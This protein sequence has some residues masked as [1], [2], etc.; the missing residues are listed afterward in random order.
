VT[1]DRPEVSFLVSTLGPA[2]H[3]Q[4]LLDSLA[5]A[6]ENVALELI[7]CDQSA[8]QQVE[9]L[10]AKEERPFAWRVTRSGRGLSRG[11]NAALSLARGQIVAFPDD[12]L[13][14]PPG[15]VE[16]VVGR[17]QREPALDGLAIALTESDGQPPSVLRFPDREVEVTPGN[18][19]L[20]VISCGLFLR[21]RLAVLIGPF[22][23]HLGAG[24][25]TRWGAGEET[26]YVLRGLAMGASV[27]F[28]PTVNTVHLDKP[29]PAAEARA[30]ARR[31]GEGIGLALRRHGVGTAHIA[32]LAARRS[33][34][35]TLLVTR[36]RIDDSRTAAAWAVGLVAGYLRRGPDDSSTQQAP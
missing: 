30:K 31:Y 23:E 18:I 26:D 10:L 1:I 15:V 36:G 5:D 3:M 12:D 14:Y 7:V 33:A 24:S 27:R 35:V 16:H 25:G 2:E 8:A 19:L 4:P 28:D 13:H 22:D 11:R 29:L 32:H 20:T 6:A 21:R 34:K 17:L 9:T